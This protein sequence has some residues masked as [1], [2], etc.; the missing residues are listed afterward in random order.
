MI[1]N[2]AQHRVDH[3]DAT[4]TGEDLEIAIAELHA[5]YPAIARAEALIANL[6]GVLAELPSD[7]AGDAVMALADFRHDFMPNVEFLAQQAVDEERDAA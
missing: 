2:E 3:D 7:Y 1:M 6:K 4:D 5:D